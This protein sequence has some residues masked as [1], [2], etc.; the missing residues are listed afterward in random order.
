MSGF[1]RHSQLNKN[2]E[3][4]MN[5]TI[6]FVLTLAVVLLTARAASAQVSIV[7]PA[8]GSVVSG[9]VSFKLQLASNIYWTQLLVDRSAVGS[10]YNLLGWDSTGVANGTHLVTVKAFA[11]GSSSALG[12]AQL[13]LVV[14]NNALS[15]TLV[16]PQNPRN[17][18]AKGNGTTDDT[19][20]F[21]SAIS[22]GDL[23]VTTGT[24]LINGGVSVP[25]Y[26]N[27]EC[28]SGV[29]LY[30]TRHSWTASGILQWISTGYGSVTDCNFKGSN[31]RPSLDSNQ[32]SYLIA[33]ATATHVSIVNDTFKNAWGN[34]AVHISAWGSQPSS[35]NSVQGCTFQSN[36]HYAVA[37]IVGTYNTISYNNVIDSSMGDE[38]N[39]TYDANTGNVFSHNTVQGVNGSGFGQVF[40]TGGVYPSGANYGGNMVFSNVVTGRSYLL[41]KGPVIP[42]QYSANTCSSG[43]TLR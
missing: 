28:D 15:T 27:I 35:Y 39:H 25:N 3:G 19:A 41:Q 8:A 18:G 22:H 23:H 4:K 30:T 29:T 36:A 6:Q 20:A 16:N 21:R 12:Q 5:K 38:V 32:G 2:Q 17:Y 9:T 7:A 42:A 14:Q 1:F 34:S 10:G 11:K 43:C 33:L 40:L 31:T 37:I 26:R 24:Y 13:N